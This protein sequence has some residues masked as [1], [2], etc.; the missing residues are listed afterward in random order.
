MASSMPSLM[1]SLM[2]VAL[3]CMCSLVAAGGMSRSIVRACLFTLV[4]TVAAAAEPG[5]AP[6]LDKLMSVAHVMT[7]SGI[8]IHAL[9]TGWVAVK[10]THRELDVPRWLAIPSIVMGRRWAGRM[11]II[12]YV[13]EHPAGVFLVDT[14]PSPRINDSDYFACDPA[15]AFFY[16]RNMRFAVPDGDTL[17]PRLAEAGID[18]DRVRTLL[19]THFHADH[20]GGVDVVPRARVLT[21]SGNWPRHTGSFT[22]RLPAGFAPSVVPFDGPSIA[23]FSA[24]HALTSDGKIHIVPLPGHTPGHVGLAVTDAGHTWLMVGDATFDGDQTLRGAVAGVSQDF[25]R[26]LATQAQLKEVSSSAS[27]TVLPAHDLSVFMRLAHGR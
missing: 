7:P 23:S 15:N 26:A 24:S 6:T 20:I 1:R 25:D 11:P 14:G 9:R 13:V 16:G 3:V 19:I 4:P 27:V 18:P 22:C 2:E 5:P 10:T 21:G 12:V 17:A 8:R